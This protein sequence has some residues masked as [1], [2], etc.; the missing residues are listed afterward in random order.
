MFTT[1]LLHVSRLLYKFLEPLLS[2][3]CAWQQG[4]NHAMCAPR[5]QYCPCKHALVLA[6]TLSRGCEG[7][8]Q[9]PL[10]LRFG[11]LGRNLA[12]R[13]FWQVHQG[14]LLG[15]SLCLR[16]TRQLCSLLLLCLR[17]QSS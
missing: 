1:N 14:L 7:L 12:I 13:H 4:C 3:M 2:N 6:G 11:F 5:T 17:L 15:R 8:L 10:R 9:L 16:H